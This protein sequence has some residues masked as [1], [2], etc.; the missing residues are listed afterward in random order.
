M[1]L[2]CVQ[3]FMTSKLSYLYCS[4]IL[5]APQASPGHSEAHLVRSTEPHFIIITDVTFLHYKV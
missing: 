2:Q 1:F 5:Q 4:V 3:E